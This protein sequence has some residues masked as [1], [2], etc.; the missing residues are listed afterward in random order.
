VSTDPSQELTTGYCYHCTAYATGRLHSVV[1]DQYAY[2]TD[3]PGCSRKPP[4]QSTRP[5]RHQLSTPT[6]R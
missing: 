4:A 1:G 2:I 6:D 3:H 5:R